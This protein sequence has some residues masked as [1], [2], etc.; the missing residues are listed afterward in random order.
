MIADP[1][2]NLEEQL[3]SQYSYDD[4]TIM[5]FN[6]YGN[7]KGTLNEYESQ[8]ITK[9]ILRNQSRQFTV[10]GM[11]KLFKNSTLH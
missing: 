9:F 3:R 8:T 6:S 7:F 5:R 2:H 1:K 4:Q 11:Y 10:P